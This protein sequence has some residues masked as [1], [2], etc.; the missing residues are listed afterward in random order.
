LTIFFAYADPMPGS[1]SSS[2]LGVA[3]LRS[4]GSFFLAS[5]LA[6][7]LVSDFAGVSFLRL[8]ERGSG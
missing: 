3:V 4:S 2:W 1:S 7:P 8:S 6:G 5:A